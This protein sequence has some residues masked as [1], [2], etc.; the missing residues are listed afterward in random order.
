MSKQY[1]L[2]LADDHRIVID[3]LHF[4]LS[5]EPQ[6]E[7]VGAAENG[8]KVIE[9]IENNLRIQNNVIYSSYLNKSISEAFQSSLEGDQVYCCLCLG[10]LSFLIELFLLEDPQCYCH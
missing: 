8:N 1:R 10:I 2:L 9:F 7:V 5:A 4:L 6:F 3:G